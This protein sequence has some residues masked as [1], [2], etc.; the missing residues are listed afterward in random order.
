MA[1]LREL[2][3]ARDRSGVVSK[4]ENLFRLLTLPDGDPEVRYPSV[5]AADDPDGRPGY[6]ELG[7]TDFPAA[8]RGERLA[9]AWRPW[10]KK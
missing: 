1:K 2:W 4:L 3:G 9:E 10:R 5:R 7:E 8:A 6:R